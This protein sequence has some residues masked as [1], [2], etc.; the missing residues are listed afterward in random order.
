M[1]YIHALTSVPAIGPS[2]VG[3]ICQKRPSYVKKNK[4][5]WKENCV[6]KKRPIDCMTEQPLRSGTP[7]MSKEPYYMS[8]ETYANQKSPKKIDVVTI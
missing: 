1:P 5:M 3:Q 2:E 7:N 6:C 4:H 8:K